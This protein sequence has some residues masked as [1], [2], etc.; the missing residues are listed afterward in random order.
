MVDPGG[1]LSGKRIL[2]TG[3]SS[4]IGL[5]ASLE[6]ARAGADVV[7]HVR[8]RSRGEAAR[9]RIAAETG[10]ERTELLLADFADLG[11]VAS[12]AEEYARRYDRL[13]V[14]AA[15]AGAIMPD[16][17]I[18]E[19][20]N[21]LT[22]QVNH[23]AHFLLCRILEPILVASGPARVVTVSSDSHQAAWRGIRFEDPA[24]R[25]GWRSF[26]AYAHSK[27][28]NI[29]FCYEHARRLFRTGVTSTVMHPG[30]VYTHFGADAYGRLNPLINKVVYP[31]IGRTP[32]RGADTLVWLAT[33]P[34]VEGATGAYFQDRRM[35]HSSRASMDLEAQRRLWEMSEELT[36]LA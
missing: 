22:F 20:G 1:D 4:G 15:N 13:D 33:S 2:V 17:V 24:F 16:H 35:H 7:M 14:L 36:G 31:T 18:T 30:F 21:E 26:P 6:F 25:R 29:M 28:A 3:A 11:A 5:A 34:E 9:E 10:S 8:D 32:E 27:L 12:A 19:H 23:L